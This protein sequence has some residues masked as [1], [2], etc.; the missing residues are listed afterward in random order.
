MS[1]RVHGKPDLVNRKNIKNPRNHISWK[2]WKYI[3]E[4]Q[5]QSEYAESMGYSREIAEAQ[6]A[7]SKL[8]ENISKSE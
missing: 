7:P 8:P 2:L 6:G 1:I 5:V 3:K 4:P